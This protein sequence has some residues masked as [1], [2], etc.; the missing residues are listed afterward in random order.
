MAYQQNGGVI[1]LIQPR[2]QTENLCLR[3]R[4]HGIGRLIG[5]QQT[6]LIRQRNGNHHLL[7]FAVG[8]FVRITA[9][10]IFVIFNPDAV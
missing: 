4:L 6:W 10:R 2:Q 7:A 9:H 1:V 3:G 5:N 8:Q